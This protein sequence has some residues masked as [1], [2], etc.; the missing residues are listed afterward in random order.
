MDAATGEFM[1]QVIFKATGS[2]RIAV[3]SGASFAHEMLAGKS[4]YM[5]LACAN[6]S[7]GAEIARTLASSQL[8]IELSRD[9]RGLEIVAVAKNMLAIGA[10]MA[11]GMGLGENFRATF[12][13][14][15]V[16]ETS[17]L[18]QSLGG[19]QATLLKIGA[20]SD[21]I[22]SCS[23]PQSRNY[24]RGLS[25]GRGEGS[26]D[27]LAEGAHSVYGFVSMLDRH[28]LRSRFF[29]SIRQAFD[30]P[31]ALAQILDFSED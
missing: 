8:H 4:V 1:S 22:L 26:S 12:I 2:D 19:E 17:R 9:I 10:G 14:R 6:D 31:S 15:G 23:S 11:V 20:L 21:V 24:Q 27:Q 25:L 5:T 3:L 16:K 29:A 28:G 7:L 18:I 13:G 30:D